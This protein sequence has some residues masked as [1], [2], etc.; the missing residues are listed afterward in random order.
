[1]EKAIRRGSVL[2]EILKQDQLSPL[3]VE[4]QMAWLVAFND[5]GFD[6][7]EIA[8]IS[9]M[10]AN[11]EKELEDSSLKLDDPRELWAQAV[12]AWM[13]AARDQSPE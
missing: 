4:F 13:K 10:L 5:G 9:A 2:R 7:V 3:P 8:S 12:S 11:L 6:D 1:M